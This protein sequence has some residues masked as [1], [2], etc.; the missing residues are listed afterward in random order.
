MTVHCV[1]VARTCAR[2]R[3]LVGACVCVWCPTGAQ[4]AGLLEGVVNETFPECAA[5]VLKD[6][7]IFGDYKDAVARITEDKEDARLYQDLGNYAAIRTILDGVLEAYNMDRKPMT[8]VRGG[9][10]CSCCAMLC[11]VVTCPAVLWPCCIGLRGGGCSMYW[12]GLD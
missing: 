9:P 8:L 11:L 5:V 1:L 10:S 3:D 6:P 12:V 2:V 4:V 7:I